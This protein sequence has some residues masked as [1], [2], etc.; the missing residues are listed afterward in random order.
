MIGKGTKLA[1]A[2]NAKLKIAIDIGHNCPPDIGAKAIGFEDQMV[3]AV[4]L[5]VIAKLKQLGHK[6]LLVTPSSSTSVTNSLY[7]RCKLAND[8][9]AD[10]FISIHANAGGGHGCEVWYESDNGLRL[11]YP[12]LQSLVNLG[13][14]NRGM[15]QCSA[16]KEHLYVIFNSNAPA[17]LV[18]ICFVDSNPD[19]QLFEAEKTANAIV[20]GITGTTAPAHSQTA[21]P[22]DLSTSSETTR[23]VQHNLNRLGFVGENGKSLSEDGILGV[24]T[25]F[26]I[27]QLQ[28]VL[29]LQVD[30]V[31]GILTQTAI[32]NVLAKTE[33]SRGMKG[34]Y[35]IRYIQFRMAI[36]ADGDFGPNTFQAVKVWQQDHKLDPDGVVGT[37]T[38]ESFI[39]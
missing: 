32:N 34:F 18:E 6:V 4:G 5:K 27:K 39:G 29:G 24:N 36:K 12:I 33:L 13:Y 16:N 10:Y 2:L 14:N 30:G 21:H 38:W 26:A 7:Q 28:A 23:Q 31:C 19:M 20:T 15:K 1:V 37:K 17:C 35:A 9:G 3:Y 11:G 8:W 25:V 22:V